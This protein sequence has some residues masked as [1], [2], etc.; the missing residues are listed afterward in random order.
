VFLHAIDS[1]LIIAN[2]STLFLFL[3][4]VR[5]IYANSKVVSI[6][7]GLLWLAFCGA[8]FLVQFGTLA[9]AIE[10]GS[11]KRCLILTLK[12]YSDTGVFLHS[13]YDT[14][15]FFAI[16]FRVAYY[17]I[18]GDTFAARMTSLFRGQGLPRFSRSILRGGQLYYLCVNFYFVVGDPLPTQDIL[19]A[20]R[21]A[22]AL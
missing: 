8:Q 11:Q 6:F 2:A 1:L 17:S 10:L 12:E 18:H 3:L 13:T 16:S 21:L 14:L 5:A 22:H 20:Q 7:F 15:I 9:I 4:R 19:P